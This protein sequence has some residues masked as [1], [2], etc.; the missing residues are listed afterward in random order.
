MKQKALSDLKIA[1]LVSGEIRN[2]NEGPADH[3]INFKNILEK[4]YVKT[5]IDIYGHTWSH[6]DVKNIKYK[7][8]FT[9]IEVNDVSMITDWMSKDILLRGVMSPGKK[10]TKD[11]TFEILEKSS[12]QHYA[13]IVGFVSGLR[14]FSDQYDYVIRTRWDLEYL[15]TR[16]RLD[17]MFMSLEE[18]AKTDVI[19]LAHKTSIRYLESAYLR[20]ILNIGIQDNFFIL[21]H[22]A[23]M[24]IVRRNIF[25]VLDNIL[26]KSHRG[27]DVPADH[28][29][30]ALYFG[31]FSRKRNI[32]MMATLPN[33]G[34]ILRQGK[35]TSE[36]PKINE[37]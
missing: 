25:E 17:E 13:Q 16:E 26:M 4:Y 14:D 30:W 7:E 20:D 11:T 10:Y 24:A 8:L 27:D 6:C 9:R 3:L 31:Y 35:K 18:Y 5:T 28:S 22:V 36:L 2:W 23:Y 21:T 37:D 29:F 33:I 15:I 12:I 32:K 19:L 1:I 34:S